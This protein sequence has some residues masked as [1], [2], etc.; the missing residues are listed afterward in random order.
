MTYAWVIERGG[1]DPSRPEYF[2]GRLHYLFPE[3]AWSAPGDHADACRFAR[4]E[5]ADKL[6]HWITPGTA[7]RIAEHGWDEGR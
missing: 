6:S 4:R 3:K 7:H 1:S 5:D 2:T